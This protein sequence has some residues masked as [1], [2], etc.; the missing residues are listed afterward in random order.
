MEMRSAGEAPARRGRVRSRRRPPG[1]G[2]EY[3][4]RGPERPR[5]AQVPMPVLSL[6]SVRAW[7]VTLPDI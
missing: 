6:P 7:V 3:L 1:E 4:P 5:E 2:R